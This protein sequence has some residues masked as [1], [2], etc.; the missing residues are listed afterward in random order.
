MVGEGNIVAD[1][2]FK[3]VVKLFTLKTRERVNFLGQGCLFSSFC[4][5]KDSSHHHPEPEEDVTTSRGCEHTHHSFLRG[6]EDASQHLRGEEDASQHLLGGG[7][8]VAVS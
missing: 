4:I 7:E 2:L 3:L 6:E 5:M 8:H 1:S